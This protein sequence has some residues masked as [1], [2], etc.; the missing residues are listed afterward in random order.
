MNRNAYLDAMGITRWRERSEAVDPCYILVDKGVRIEVE[1]P[2]VK[3][4]LALLNIN[5]EQVKVSTVLP[6]SAGKSSAIMWD[7]RCLKHPKVECILSSPPLSE[8]EQ[9]VQAKKQ[10][11]QSI[12]SWDGYLGIGDAT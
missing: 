9:T 4:V 12:H 6:K 2:I 1:H 8:L 3:S 10:L 5:A 7:L 11:W